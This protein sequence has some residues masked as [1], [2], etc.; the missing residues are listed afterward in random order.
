MSQPAVVTGPVV[1]AKSP[2]SHM[3]DVRRVEAVDPPG[4]AGR[5]LA[6]NYVNVVVFSQHGA[7][8]LPN[9]LAGSDLVRQSAAEVG[10][11]SMKT[12]VCRHTLPA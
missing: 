6:A 11:E 12:A 4:S 2:V 3:G 1:L 5:L 9:M 8:P 7:R 10:L